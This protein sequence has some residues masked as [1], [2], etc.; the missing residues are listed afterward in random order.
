MILDQT[1][2]L[3]TKLLLLLLLSGTAAAGG[4]FAQNGT[5][6][7]TGNLY[8]G[9]AGSTLFVNSTSGFVGIGTANSTRPLH[10]AAAQDANIRLQDTL[11][12]N[13]AAYIEFYNDTTRWGYFGLGGHDDRMV[14]G[15][16]IEKNFSFYTNNTSR[17]VIT[18]SG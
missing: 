1:G 16:T 5:L 14:I 11:G 6:N 18:P 3:G 7:A 2:R 15:T 4:V 13:P 17:I 12:A 8:M 10:I 9:P